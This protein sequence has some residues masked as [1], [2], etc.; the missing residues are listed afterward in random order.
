MLPRHP[1]GT[2]A[3]DQHPRSARRPGGAAAGTPAKRRPWLRS[4]VVRG[5]HGQRRP[6]PCRPARCGQATT[7]PAD[8]GHV[9]SLRPAGAA[10]PTEPLQVQRGA[11]RAAAALRTPKACPSGHLDAPDAW[12]PDAWTPDVR[13]TGWTDIPRW[14]GRGGQG[15]D[16]PGRRPDTLATGD[17]PPGRPT[18]PGHGA[19]GRS[20][21]D[22]S[23]VMAPA[24]RPDRRRHWTAASTARHEAAPRRTALVLELDGTR[25]A[26][27]LR[28]GEGVLGQAC[29]GVLMG[30]RDSR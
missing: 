22:G 10:R 30:C 17:H 14:T 15:N 16:R 7:P 5:R 25:R 18:S 26:M 21:Q 11:D 1:A 27:G 29:K 20:T 6:L 28:K 4:T 12:T 9:D 13:S 2:L 24:P 23:A 8:T 19:R 3:L